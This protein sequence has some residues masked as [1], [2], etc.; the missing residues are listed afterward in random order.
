MLVIKD[1][2]ALTEKLDIMELLAPLELPV[3]KVL[4]VLWVKPDP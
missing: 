1:Q 3:P 4:K 2:L